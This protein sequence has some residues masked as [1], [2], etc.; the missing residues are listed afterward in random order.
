MTSFM[1]K[2]VDVVALRSDDAA[3]RRR[4]RIDLEVRMVADGA[5]AYPSSSAKVQD[6]VQWERR[7]SVALARTV[8]QRLLGGGV[9]AVVGV[10]DVSE[11]GGSKVGVEQW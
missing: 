1:K 11:S 9:D 2:M 3:R 4:R 7:I 5:K 6:L 8:G 10:A